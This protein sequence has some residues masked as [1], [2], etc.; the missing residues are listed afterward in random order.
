M[1]RSMSF[2][3]LLAALVPMASL[4]FDPITFLP[5]FKKAFWFLP[6]H[7]LFPAWLFVGNNIFVFSILLSDEVG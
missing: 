1:M 7:I 4:I 5:L 2:T 3:I 6:I